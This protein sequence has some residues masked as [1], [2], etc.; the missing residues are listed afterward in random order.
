MQWIRTRFDEPRGS[1]PDRVGKR[2]VGRSVPEIWSRR[3]G[4]Q[5]V[6]YLFVAL[7]KIALSIELNIIYTPNLDMAIKVA[8]NTALHGGWLKFANFGIL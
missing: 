7:V 4:P 2:S 1:R 8:F 6:P 3:G 5:Y